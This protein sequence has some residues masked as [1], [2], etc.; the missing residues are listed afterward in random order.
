MGG[1]VLLKISSRSER[2]RC[3]A[4][5]CSGLVKATINRNRSGAN[6]S[7]N[8]SIDTCLMNENT[9]RMTGGLYET[10]YIPSF[11]KQK[12]TNLGDGRQCP[13]TPQVYQTAGPSC[14]GDN[15]EKMMTPPPGVASVCAYV[16]ACARV[17]VR[18]QVDTGW[19]FP[20]P[21]WESPA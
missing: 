7:S 8:T 5:Q 6:Q 14:N 19:P 11:R 2:K 17:C 10:L 18:D 15:A 16:R 20:P 4:M 21:V 13:T 1:N 12:K 3:N 9:H